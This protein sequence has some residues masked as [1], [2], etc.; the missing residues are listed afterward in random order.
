MSQFGEGIS[1]NSTVAHRAAVSELGRY[2]DRE[3]E[4]R[5]ELAQ[6]EALLR[7]KDDLIDQ[8]EL[9]HRESDHRLLNDLQ[10]VM[11]LL[12]LQSKTSAN[13]ETAEQLRIAAD[14]VAMVVRV[15]RRLHCLD[16]V[17]TVAF[18]QYLED[19]CH[20][21]SKMLSS[22]ERTLQIII[23]GDMEFDLPATTGVALGFIVSELL[24]NAAKYGKGPITVTLKPDPAKGY[25]LSISNEGAALPEGFDPAA[26]KGLGMKI[27][28]SF[29]QRIKGELRFSR[30]DRNQGTVFTVLF[31]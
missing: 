14:R 12:S 21:F 8:Q 11:S 22:E 31:S 10:M 26:G 9:L 20:D 7:Q 3:A 17:E 25:A 18:K 23:A 16:G 6:Y 4:L 30:S 1:S 29:V 28:R 15:H 24:A 5:L 13:A 27:I 19:L 2:R